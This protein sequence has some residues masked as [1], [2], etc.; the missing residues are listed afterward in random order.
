MLI[1]SGGV[2]HSQIVEILLD[3]ILKIKKIHEFQDDSVHELY[4][5]I[6]KLTIN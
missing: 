2:A 5:E 3:T 1:N 6:F 4:L